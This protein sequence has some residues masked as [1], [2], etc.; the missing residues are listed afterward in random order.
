[1]SALEKLLFM[2]KLAPIK[3]EKLIKLAEKLGFIEKRQAG[4]HKSFYHSDGRV[5]TIPFHRGK[6]IQVGLLNR[7]IKNDLKISREEFFK[8]L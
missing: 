1:M 6:E 2:P 7:M 4:S 5:L 8:L 3:P